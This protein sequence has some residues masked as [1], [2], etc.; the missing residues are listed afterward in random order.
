MTLLYL[1]LGLVCYVALAAL[2]EWVARTE[3]TEGNER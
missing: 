2:I 1:A 3:S